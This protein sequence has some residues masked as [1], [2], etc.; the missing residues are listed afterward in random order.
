MCDWRRKLINL[1][2]FSTYIIW[3]EMRT[4]MLLCSSNSAQQREM[5]AH[6]GDIDS[7][8]SCSSFTL[9]GCVSI[10][11]PWLYCVNVRCF[12]SSSFFLKTGTSLWDYYS[13]IVWGLLILTTGRYHISRTSYHVMWEQGWTH[14]GLPY[15]FPCVSNLFSHTISCIGY[16]VPACSAFTTLK[17]RF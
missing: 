10:P 9:K 1:A 15:G 11:S 2:Y 16:W 5:V 4:R 6:R 3:T 7:R 14:C 12:F 17:A 13:C 8:Q